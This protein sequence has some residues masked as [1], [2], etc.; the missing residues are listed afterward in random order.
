VGEA[1]ALFLFDFPLL[2]RLRADLGDEAFSFS[3]LSPP[4]WKKM[5]SPPLFFF[6]PSPRPERCMTATWARLPPP[7]SPFFFPSP[8]FFFFAQ[9]RT[10]A[11]THRPDGPLPRALPFFRG[12]FSGKKEASP[13][14]PPL[15][16][17]LPPLERSLSLP[18]PGRRCCE[19][20]G[21]MGGR[22]TATGSQFF[23]FFPLTSLTP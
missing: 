11:R 12:R 5:V 23:P 13:S 18:P 3:P 1:R 17:P 22:R 19:M 2:L 7:P 9:Y 6:T 8:P 10:V 20:V 16:P 15:P 4:G 21:V 14:S